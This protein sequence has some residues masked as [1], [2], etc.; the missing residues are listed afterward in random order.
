MTTITTQEKL[1]T[2]KQFNC[3]GCGASLSVLNPRA[4][5]IACQYC[6]SVL[7]VNSEQHQ[8]LSALG[9][10]DRYHPLSFI[11]LGM[12]G[13]FNG[14]TYQVIARTRVRMKYKEYW[15]EDGETGY[16]N[17]TWIFD[18]WLMIDANRT[19]FYLIEDKEG[20][21]I[22]EEI[23]PETPSLLPSNLRMSLFQKQSPQIVREYGDAEIIHFE[24]ESNYRITTGDR[25]RF[26]MYRDRG[27]EYSV[28]WRLE[29]DGASIKEIE[30]FREVPVSRRKLIE[31]FSNNE[32]IEK[33]RE[34]EGKWRFVFQVSSLS[35]V[36]LLV[37]LIYS[38]A[39]SGKTVFRQD[40]EIQNLNSSSPVVSQDIVV[41]EG[42]LFSLDMEVEF[43]TQNSEFYAFAYIMDADS[44]AISTVENDF[45]YY[46][47]YE[48]GE[49]WTESDMSV[50]KVFRLK[51]PGNYHLELYKN[52]ETGIPES[53][54]TMKIELKKGIL[55][56]RYFI[57]G[58]I[59]LAIPTFIAFSRKGSV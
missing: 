32:E 23:I 49:S 26:A 12:T 35:M 46:A 29:K 51:E 50:S 37:M 43:M 22:S 7:D 14:K 20:Y 41:D 17:E 11:R 30:F 18:E 3:T 55:L 39:Y 2:V 53:S 10:P 56:S 45:Y 33:L 9:K 48:D 13:T 25:L 47:G 34:S 40:F 8:I 16:S 31:A 19:Y 38:I 54:G 42:G 6:G 15:A 28:E 4:Q 36:A 5:N 21:L 27:I 57:L 24:G 58:L 52:V 44:G 1:A 59:I